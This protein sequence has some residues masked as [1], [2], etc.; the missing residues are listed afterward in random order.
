MKYDTLRK[1][2]GDERLKEPPSPQTITTKSSRSIVDTEA[3]GGLGTAC[4]RTEERID[5][6]WVNDAVGRPFSAV[7][8]TVD[9]G[10]L[11]TLEEDIIPRLLR[12]VPEQPGLEKLK[13]NPYLSRLIL[14]FDREGYS[15]AFFKR[16]WKTYRISC[17]TYHTF[18]DD[19]WPEEWFVEQQVT[20][21]R[22]E[23]VAL[24]LAEM[25]S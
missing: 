2:I 13:E 8:K 17:I 24:R 12:D 25:G 7:E 15:P 10:M 3:A 5:D 21:P 14:V 23:T 18:P 9:P 20:M 16:M 4:T 19:A 1:A 22:G 11:K 6:Y